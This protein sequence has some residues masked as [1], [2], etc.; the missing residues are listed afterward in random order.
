MRQLLE[1]GSFSDRSFAAQEDAQ[2]FASSWQLVA[3]GTDLPAAGDHTL[4]S[5]AGRQWVLRRGADG[6]VYAFAN[7]CLHRGARLCSARGNGPVRCSYHGWT[8]NDRGALMG[9][10]FRSDFEEEATFHGLSLPTARVEQWGPAIFLQPESA[11]PTLAE[12]LGPLQ[13]QL[14]PLFRA[15]EHPLE[16][17]SIEIAANWK[18]VMENAL[19]TYHVGLIHRNSIQPLGF[20]VTRTDFHGAH[21]V[22]HYSAPPSARKR[23]A[24]DF[25]YPGRPIA[26]DGYLH[27]NVF[28]NST[29]AT[30]YGNFFVLTRTEPLGP[31]K[32]RLHWYM[33]STRCDP[34]SLAAADAAQLMDESNRQ[35]LRTT[36][37]EDASICASAHQGCLEATS[38]G[39]LGLQERRVLAFERELSVR[40][41]AARAKSTYSGRPSRPSQE[42]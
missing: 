18:I 19:E 29:V 39:Y 42:S 20:E 40:T 14:D 5:V 13:L 17:A 25:A 37:E 7:V 16:Q 12:E 3:L 4:V 9:V 11:G 1:P 38:H 15:M 27:A 21:S 31:E 23:R 2:V 26:I 32:T 34:R 33:L 8:Y 36:F 10:P 6:K 35:F 24:L 30:A 28:P 41:S 22:S